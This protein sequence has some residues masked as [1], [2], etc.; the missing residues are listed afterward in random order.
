[1]SN[2]SFPTDLQTYVHKSRYARWK[3]KEKRRESWDE[4]V[5]RYVEFFSKRFPDA[6]PSERISEAIRSC[7]SMPS[8]R[9][10]MTAGPA[11]DRDEIAG[12]NC[13]Y[14]AIDH[15][16]AFDEILYLS[17]CGTGVGFSVERQNIAKL[18]AVPEELNHSDTTI[19]VSDSKIGWA[20]SLKELIGLLYSGNIPRWDVSRV[21]PV[22]ERLKTFG[23]RAS[24]P[25][26][27]EELFRFV[28]ETFKGA[29]GRK[30]T[31]IECHDIVC[32]IGDVIV[33]GG[34]RRCLPGYYEVKTSLGWK[35]MD[36]LKI[37][38]LIDLPEGKFPVNNIFDSGIQETVSILTENGEHV[39][40]KNH[41]WLSRNIID[42]TI[43]WVEAKNLDPDIH[44]LLKEKSIDRVNY[45][46]IKIISIK[47]GIL[48]HVFDIEVDD[49]H[50][51]SARNPKTGCESISH[52]SALISL[53]NLSDDRMRSAKTG[54]WWEQF[55]HRSLSNNSAVYSERPDMSV[56]F[57]E[58]HSLFES[59]SGERGIFS[60]YSAIKK[61][62]ENGRRETDGHEYGTNP[63]VV[64][65]TKVTT[66]KGEMTMRELSSLENL[67][68]VEVQTW[69]PVSE[70]FV[71]RP[72]LRAFFTK[73]TKDLIKITVSSIDGASKE[74]VLTPDHKVFT[75]NRGWV[76]AKDLNGDDSLVVLYQT[77]G[78]IQKIEVIESEEDVFDLTV[79]GLHSFIANGILIKNCGEIILR[80]YGLCNLTEVVVRTD[81]TLEDLLEKIET[82]TIMGT[83]Q[84]T[85]TNFRYVRSVWKKNAEEERL[86]GVSLTGIMDHEILSGRRGQGFL[87]EWL[88]Q[89]RNKAISTNKVWADKLGI[90]V[91]AAITTVKPSG[92]TTLDTEVKTEDGIKPMH[93]IFLELG[94][95]PDSHIVPGTWIEPSKALRVFDE[96]N[97]LQTITKLFV[98][99]MSE[100]F[101]IQLEDGTKAR[102]TPDHEL[103]TTSGWKKC[104][105]LVEGDDIVSF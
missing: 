27:L 44:V 12:Y 26:P 14:V 54:N 100:L 77:E 81:D 42:G 79:E 4:T 50:R 33:S 7:K 103:K 86:L 47:A 21:R 5:Q 87:I 48:E 20:S 98:N 97:E 83:F 6:Y 18:P 67:E 3:E 95:E 30:L 60:R 34:V 22:G 88:E 31:S 15:P 84:S 11:L 51:F 10:L 61:A 58:W 105:D 70:T 13:S 82:A 102:F 19:V 41:R 92:C 9:A 36:E 32:K 80:P 76:E 37:G 43:S 74:L 55:V 72:I 45:E 40:T 59:K 85:L 52:N 38:D 16:R 2:K 68:G 25:G 64:G 8:M 69:D 23:G 62:K 63:C 90:P 49:V 99:G 104:K 17:A 57:K 66:N 39:S 91:S 96:N 46:E 94:F 35:K 101:E 93:Q 73:R 65:D 89:M 29:A 1:M 53:S 75:R 28:I 24:G 71:F 78:R 56:F